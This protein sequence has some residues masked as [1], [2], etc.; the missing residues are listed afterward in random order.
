M[1]LNSWIIAGDHHTTLVTYA[2][3]PKL[4]Y[5]AKIAS[6]SLSKPIALF[7]NRTAAA[8]KITPRNGVFTAF[9]NSPKP[10]SI[11]L[12]ALPSR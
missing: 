11:C 6:D 9:Q 12:M 10:A 8:I 5:I 4:I 2:I 1:L 7:A 3:A